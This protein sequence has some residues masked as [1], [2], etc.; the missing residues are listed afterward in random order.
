[1][2]QNYPQTYAPK[3]LLSHI[4]WIQEKLSSLEEYQKQ[5]PKTEKEEIFC[6]GSQFSV[7]PIAKKL[8]TMEKI[9]FNATPYY[10]NPTNIFPKAI[11]ILQTSSPAIRLSTSKIFVEC[12]NEKELLQKLTVWRFKNC[13]KI[14]FLLLFIIMGNVFRKNAYLCTSTRHKNNI[15]PYKTKLTNSNL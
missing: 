15:P 9:S 1:M 10:F 4:D 2:P 11:E 6:F 5:L 3:A 7:I 8:A 14:S 12:K 13:R